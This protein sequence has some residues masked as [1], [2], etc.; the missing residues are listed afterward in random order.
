MIGITQKSEDK[1]M[2]RYIWFNGESKY[3]GHFKS[4]SA[5]WIKKMDGLR[6]RLWLNKK[7]PKITKVG[8][9]DSALNTEWISLR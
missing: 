9:K 3:E 4:D 7:A 5:F 6:G 8:E 1:E 2:I